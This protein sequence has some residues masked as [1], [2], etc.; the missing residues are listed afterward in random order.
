MITIEPFDESAWSEAWAL[1]RPVFARGDTL[2]HPP[3]T[4][5]TDAH[6][7]WVK[8]PLATFVA[9]D[10]NGRVVGLYYLK[11]NAPGL[12]SHVANAG[13]VVSQAARGRGVAAQ[14]CEHSQAE[15][16][17]CGF[18]AMQF[19]YVVSTNE[20]AVHLWQKMGFSIVGRVPEAFRHQER[21]LVDVLVMWK[22]LA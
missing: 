18:Q 4:S 1:L 16:K 13:Y 17:R 11:A 6:G 2:A 20:A 8:A 12:G 19:N 22:R 3:D 14:L 7:A 15:A 10:E 21:G 5:E 9:R